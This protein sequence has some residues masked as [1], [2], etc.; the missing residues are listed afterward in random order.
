MT[1]FTVPFAALDLTEHDLHRRFDQ[2]L[3]EPIGEHQLERQPQV[4]T[5][6]W[7]NPSGSRKSNR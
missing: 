5:L 2:S 4:V 1:A 6:L 7:G 3:F